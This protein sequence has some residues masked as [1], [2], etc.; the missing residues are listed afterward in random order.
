MTDSEPTKEL[1]I[2][3]MQIKGTGS[4]LPSKI[5]TNDDLSK[6]IETSDEWI[7]ERTGIRQRHIS[8]GETVV[9]LSAS[10]CLEAMKDANVNPEDIELIILA[11]CSPEV[12]IPNVACQV[13]AKIGAVNAV[14]FDMNAACSGFLFALN[15]VN[16]YISSG[17]YKNALVIGA[18]VLSKIVDWTDRGTCILFGD[19]AGCA[20]VEATNEDVHYDFVQH[21]DGVKG[22]VLTCST[23]D[24]KNP[25]ITEEFEPRFVSMDG[26]EIFKFAVSQVPKCIEECLDKGN[27]DVK[28]IDYF[29]LHQ[30]NLRIISSISKKLGVDIE[31]FPSNV[32][33]VGNTSSASI[34]ILLDEVNKKGLLKRGMKL[35][36]SG[37]GAGL[38]YGAS[39]I[40]W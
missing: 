16:A 20:Y 34:P 38:T 15:V 9:S 28:D 26:R 22:D 21:S 14:A 6:I 7:S 36:L 18:E 11:T 40:T 2:M 25:Y 30:A 32:D 10:A 37:F 17:I 1:S 31:K 5:M 39:I 23:R 4:A 35:V 13:Q 3:N 19:G 24:L 27:I 8:T 33:K 29:I 12:M